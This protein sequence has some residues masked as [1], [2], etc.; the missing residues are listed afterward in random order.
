[1][2]THDD[3]AARELFS[4]IRRRFSLRSAT[5]R[6]AAFGA[7]ATAPRPLAT[8]PQFPDDDFNVNAGDDSQQA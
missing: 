7:R 8:R 1:M 5:P 4:L 3:G 2:A 6:K